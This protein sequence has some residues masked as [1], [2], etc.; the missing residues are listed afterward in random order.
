MI[1][2][3]KATFTQG[4]FSNLCGVYAIVNAVSIL[5]DGKRSDENAKIPDAK[6][7]YFDLLRYVEAEFG[8]FDTLKDGLTAKEMR[9]LS[10]YVAKIS[11]T[12]IRVSFPR[13]KFDNIA[14][15]FGERLRENQVAIVGF[16]G[17]E[18]HWSVA[19]AVKDGALQLADSDVGRARGRECVSIGTSKN[20]SKR[21]SKK[22]CEELFIMPKQTILL[23][24]CHD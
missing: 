16:E 2:K 6:D 22:P 10:R 17:S 20:K 19:Y 11:K 3:H 9:Q 1:K 18:Q 7:L 5:R 21:R 24:L 12:K 15:W 14:D 4:S 23:E 8:T 13:E